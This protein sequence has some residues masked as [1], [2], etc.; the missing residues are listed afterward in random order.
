MTTSPPYMLK[1]ILA[2]L[3]PASSVA[4]TLVCEVRMDDQSRCKAIPGMCERVFR[5]NAEKRT[6]SEVSVDRNSQGERQLTVRKWS[7]DRIEAV[8]GETGGMNSKEGQTLFTSLRIVSLD[9]VLGLFQ[10]FD[11]Y[12]DERGEVMSTDAIERLN[13]EEGFPGGVLFG[14]LPSRRMESGKCRIQERAF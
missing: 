12:H 9:R 6:I 11:E 4:Q 2:L 3:L 13:R 14:A 8:R 10:T 7:E 5:L 1:L